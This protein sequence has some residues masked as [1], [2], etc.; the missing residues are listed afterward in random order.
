MI[1]PSARSTSLF[2]PIQSTVLE[3][4]GIAVVLKNESGLQIKGE[5]EY[6]ATRLAPAQAMQ[7]ASPGRYPIELPPRGERVVALRA[8]P[9]ANG[10][11]LNISVVGLSASGLN[12]ESASVRLDGSGLLTVEPAK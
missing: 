5:I 3:N 7:G 1:V 4:A 9:A 8:L 11:V 12:G 10:Q 2:L 6:D